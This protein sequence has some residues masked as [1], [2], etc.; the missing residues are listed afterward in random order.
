MNI[1]VSRN[2]RGDGNAATY[3][4]PPKYPPPPNLIKEHQPISDS[5][6]GNL[7]SPRTVA[8]PPMGSKSD[9]SFTQS[10]SL[11]VEFDKGPS[12]V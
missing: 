8:Y 10:F 2:I 4:T 11:E 1:E 7:L 3:V 6:F 12:N 5:G 9:R